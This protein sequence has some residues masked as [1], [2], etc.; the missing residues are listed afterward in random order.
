L[1]YASIIRCKWGEVSI[2]HIGTT[3]KC[4]GR[5]LKIPDPLVFFSLTKVA[6]AD[7]PIET[8]SLLCVKNFIIISYLRI[9][10][11]F[12]LDSRLLL[13]RLRQHLSAQ[14][15]LLL[16]TARSKLHR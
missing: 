3:H 15:F 1:S 9:K 8:Q 5:R 14:T 11:T 13:V 10:L 2:T 16:V 12:R 4:L 7:E 6:L